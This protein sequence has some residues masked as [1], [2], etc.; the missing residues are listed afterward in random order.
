M[1]SFYRYKMYRLENYN[2]TEKQINI[3]HYLY[4]YVYQLIGKYCKAPPGVYE[5][6]RQTSPF[7]RCSITHKL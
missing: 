6:H 2:P 5:S 4:V 3:F 7:K 1:Y